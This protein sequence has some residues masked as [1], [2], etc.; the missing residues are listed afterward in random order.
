MKKLT[1]DLS[2]AYTSKV[3]KCTPL[4]SRSLPTSCFT[5]SPLTVEITVVAPSGKITLHSSPVW[6][7][8][9]NETD[10]NLNITLKKFRKTI[11]T[12]NITC[13]LLEFLWMRARSDEAS[14]DLLPVNS[15]RTELES[16]WTI[17]SS[18]PLSLDL[19]LDCPEFFLPHGKRDFLRLSSASLWLFFNWNKNAIKL[20]QNNK[21]S[22][23]QL[24]FPGLGSSLVCKI[25]SGSRSTWIEWSVASLYDSHLRNRG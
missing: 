11:E 13:L 15:E 5:V 25:R 22:S 2:D 19:D 4:F 9:P 6:L 1:L 21:I 10:W 12:N 3:L 23:Q 16:S 20:M 14:E 24:T 7:T 8:S 17:F 18:A